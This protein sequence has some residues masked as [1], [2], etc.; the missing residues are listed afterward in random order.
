MRERSNSARAARARS[1]CA[2]GEEAAAEAE[3]EGVG[4]LG[5]EG[6]AG[7]VELQLVEGV[8]QL[9]QLV[10]VDG[11]QP[12]K[13]HGLG[14]AVAGER[15]GGRCTAVVTVSPERAP[16][17]SLMPAMRYRPRRPELVDGDADG[18]AHPELFDV[19]DGPRCM[20]R[21]RS[22]ERMVPSMTRTEL[23]TPRY[24]S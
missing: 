10:A 16:P 24:W 13:D 12:A 19:V 1:P 11:V 18:S 6:E 3:A 17:T 21:S 4:G 2:R 14:V 8:T 22:E 20:K 5:F 9:G 15:L 23:M 7:V